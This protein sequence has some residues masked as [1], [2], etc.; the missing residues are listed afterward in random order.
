MIQVIRH[1][2]SVLHRTTVA[3]RLFFIGVIV[4]LFASTKDPLF[5]VV[6]AVVSLDVTLTVAGL[7]LDR[8]RS[9]ARSGA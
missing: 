8:T 5:M 1:D 2:I 9:P 3:I 6:L 4:W 7:L